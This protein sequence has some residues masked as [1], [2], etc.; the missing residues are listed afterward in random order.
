MYSPWPASATPIAAAPED[1]GVVIRRVRTTKPV[2]TEYELTQKGRALKS[3]VFAVES[4][5]DAWVK[6][7][8]AT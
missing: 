5:A 8:R 1:E 3:V 4:W 2:L 6:P 7:D